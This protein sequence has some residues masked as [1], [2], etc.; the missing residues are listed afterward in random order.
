MMAILKITRGYEFVS[1]NQKEQALILSAI[2]D[3]AKKLCMQWPEKKMIG[4]KYIGNEQLSFVDIGCNAEKFCSYLNF[5]LKD[6]KGDAYLNESGE[7]VEITLDWDIVAAEH[8]QVDQSKLLP[9]FEPVP[10]FNEDG[11]QIDEE[12]VTDLTNKLQVWAGKK[13]IF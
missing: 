7:S 13:W 10:V 3:I 2:E 5:T 1:Y 9:W 4:T 6:E 11:E 8:E 12:P